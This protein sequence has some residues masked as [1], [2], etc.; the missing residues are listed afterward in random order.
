[1]VFRGHLKYHFTATH[2]DNDNF[3]AQFGEQSPK[4]HFFDFRLK[5]E[6]RWTNGIPKFIMKCFPST[7]IRQK[8]KMTSKLP[9]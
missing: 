5:A 7:V 4:D 8:H 6:N 2:Y 1:M 9:V 3:I